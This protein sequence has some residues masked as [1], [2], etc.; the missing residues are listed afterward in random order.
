VQPGESKIGLGVRARGT[1]HG[2]SPGP[3]GSV[4]TQHGLADPRFSAHHQDAAFAAR[5]HPEQSLDLAALA[6]AA[7][8]ART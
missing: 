2:R 6:F 5:S 8:Q 1:Q 4:V 7:H 3:P